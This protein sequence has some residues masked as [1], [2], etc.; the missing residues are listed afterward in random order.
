MEE[1]PDDILL[2]IFQFIFQ[3]VRDIPHLLRVCSSWNRLIRYKPGAL[4]YLTATS[5]HCFRISLHWATVSLRGWMNV[6][7][8]PACARPYIQKLVVTSV[9]FFDHGIFSTR[10][11]R[12]HT[13]SVPSAIFPDTLPDTLPKLVQVS[14]RS[15]GPSLSG[16]IH[17]RIRTVTCQ[18]IGDVG[19]L[20]RK[21]P[22]LDTL[23]YGNISNNLGVGV[24]DAIIHRNETRVQIE[25][26]DLTGYCH[27]SPHVDLGV[28]PL[29]EC[30][31]SHRS[32]PTEAKN[33]GD[34]ENLLVLHLPGMKSVEPL[35]R[36]PFWKNLSYLY[37]DTR[38]NHLW[39]KN[40]LPSLDSLAL[41]ID[42]R[43]IPFP[44]HNT[45]PMTT[46]SSVFISF[47]YDRYQWRA[48]QIYEYILVLLAEHVPKCT[49]INIYTKDP[50]SFSMKHTSLRRTFPG[51][52]FTKLSLECWFRTY[53]LPSVAA[54]T[55][56]L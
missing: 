39:Y 55:T 48:Q 54:V 41:N 20:F 22:N 52:L 7:R 29:A 25:Q 45:A 28:S 12:L 4:D 5:V 19:E 35:S 18:T 53:I 24:D 43:R 3:S 33:L 49:H 14:F 17:P 27:I 6:N 42:S 10:W 31:V 2:C 50:V 38:Y 8:I 1:Q 21:F 15:I 26:K 36:M 30:F 9:L 11:N 34:A 16:E 13:L 37:V 23:S 51:C 32:D 56:L 47:N 44:R 46:I 40:I